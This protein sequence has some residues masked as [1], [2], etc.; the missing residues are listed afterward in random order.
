MQEAHLHEEEHKQS[1]FFFWFLTDGEQVW[2]Y[3]IVDGDEIEE[4]ERM[5]EEDVKEIEL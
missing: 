2:Q 3:N 4:V 1:I 5:D